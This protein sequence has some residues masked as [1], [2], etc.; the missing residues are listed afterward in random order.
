MMGIAIGL[1]L[2]GFK[3]LHLR[4]DFGLGV[5]QAAIS[6][7]SHKLR[8]FG[9][10]LLSFSSVQVSMLVDFSYGVGFDQILVV[11]R[12]H[13][14]PAMLTIRKSYE[15]F[16][17]SLFLLFWDLG[18]RLWSGCRPWKPGCPNLSLGLLVP[19]TVMAQELPNSRFPPVL[20]LLIDKGEGNPE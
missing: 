12:L 3:K 7:L 4:Q 2:S 19:T 11:S 15:G 5:Q 8:D 13:D 20:T 16:V 9:F 17:F 1:A 10:A 6:S 18:T 14:N